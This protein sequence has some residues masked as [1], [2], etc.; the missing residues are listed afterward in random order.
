MNKVRIGKIVHIGNTTEG[1]GIYISLKA[2]GIAR[3]VQPFLLACNKYGKQ[4][5]IILG[6]KDKDEV[7]YQY[8]DKG[9]IETIRLTRKYHKPMKKAYYIYSEDKDNWK[10]IKDE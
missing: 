4:F 6:G 2:Y 1:Y 3:G 7:L 5:K 8:Y 9:R 10:K